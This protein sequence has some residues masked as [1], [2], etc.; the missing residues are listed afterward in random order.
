MTNPVPGYAIT[1]PFGKRGKYWSTDQAGDPLKNTRKGI[2]GRAGWGIHTGSDISGPG[3]GGKTILSATPGRVI[4][5]YAHD[6]SYGWK[7]IVR[8]GKYDVWY[9]HMPKPGT[10]PWNGKK[11]VKVGQI[12]EAGDP[13]GVVGQSGNTTGAHLHMELRIAGG[14]FAFKNFY[15]PA[16]A[17][18]YKPD[19]PTPPP[20]AVWGKP[21]TFVIGATGPDV[22]RLGERIR[23][24]FKHFGWVDPYKVAPGSPMSEVDR[25]ALSKL[26]VAWGLGDSP[27][28]LKKG[29]GSDGYPG[30]WSFM[31][32]LSDPP[33]KPSIATPALRP[34]KT[35]KP[36]TLPSSYNDYHVPAGVSYAVG[37]SP[38]GLD[39]AEALNYPAI[40]IDIHVTKDGVIVAGHDTSPKDDKFVIT[41][42]IAAKY[43]SN[44]KIE[45]MLWADVKQLKT[46]PVDWLG[47]KITLRYYTLDELL[48][49][50]SKH[51][52][53]KFM[54]ELKQ[55]KP[56]ENPE[57][58][59]SIRGMAIKH[60]VDPKRIA[61]MSIIWSYY[62]HLARFKAAHP[63]FTTVALRH[64]LPKPSYWSKVEPHVDH[65]RGSW[66]KAA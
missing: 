35:T 1:T 6:S 54:L 22:T 13:I 32:L 55:S 14:G 39:R 58:Y 60:G 18:N 25:A 29:G 7:V 12:V 28:A 23:V 40:D 49:R 9:C 26:Q 10:T 45:N 65:Y 46:K 61:V 51:P 41:A 37:N 38:Y 17:I 52:K 43:G 64:D 21:D 20:V 34:P 63:Y 66:G 48:E 57:T 16:I 42:A 33:V 15:N 4:A 36:T 27:A 11:T 50:L 62:D 3:V 59:E 5:A 44:P 8:W 24:W 30:M 19:A 2:N 31:K 56:F 53:M 47:K